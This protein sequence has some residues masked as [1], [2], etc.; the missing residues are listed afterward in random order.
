MGGVAIKLA[1]A[2]ALGLLGLFLWLGL[3]GCTSLQRLAHVY[4]GQAPEP[5]RFTYRD[6]GDG[7]YSMRQSLATRHQRGAIGFDI[8]AGWR[9]I[10]NDP[11]SVDKTWYGS[12]YR[13]RS[14]IM[15][16][17]PVADALAL[18]IPIFVA[19]GRRG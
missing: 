9:E 14:D 8:D 16:I 5:N 19:I 11:R 18:K 1:A 7:G 3:S 2:R 4:G 13:W 10:A 15:D 6:G 17:D 12:T